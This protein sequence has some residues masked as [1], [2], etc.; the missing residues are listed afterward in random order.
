MKSVCSAAIFFAAT[1]LFAQQSFLSNWTFN[2]RIEIRANYRDSRHERFAI[3]FKFPPEFL[4]VGETSAFEE[5]PDAGHRLEVS[6]LQIRL[7]AKYG[8]LLTA[9]AQVHAQDKYR[10]NPTRSDRQADAAELWIR[11][12]E[13]P[14]FLERPEHTSFFAQIG[15]APKMERQPIRLLGSYGLA[16]TSFN[17]MEDTQLL[18]GGTVGRN[19]YWRLQ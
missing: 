4:P 5:T 14:D 3:R 11:I 17:R 13:K 15:K 1:S 6:V 7:D 16:A 12:G 10:R 8:K 19:L 9:H 2:E 18:V